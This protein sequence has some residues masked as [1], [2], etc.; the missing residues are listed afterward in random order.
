M[1]VSFVYMLAWG[2]LAL[3]VLLCRSERSKELEI[4]WVPKT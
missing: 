4:L 3:V 2:V 1:V